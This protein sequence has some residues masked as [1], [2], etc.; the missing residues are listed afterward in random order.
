MP[1]EVEGRNGGTL[2]PLM[3]G[4]P[5][6]PGAG[7]KKNPFK[8]YIQELA[9]NPGPVVMKG[10][11]LRADGTGTGETVLVAVQMPNA[12]EVVRKMYDRA[13]RRGDVQ[14]AKWLVETAFGKNIKLGEDEENP[15][16]VGFAVVLPE[17]SR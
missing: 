3:K 1:K 16:S 6:V 7:R 10:E 8:Q 9:D 14:A 5:G 11:L 4:D 15:L 12:L 13:A 2:L 17:N